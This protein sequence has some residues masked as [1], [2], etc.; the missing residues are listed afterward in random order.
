MK[1]WLII[2]IL[3]VATRSFSETSEQLAGQLAEMTLTSN[4]WAQLI[5]VWN[6]HAAASN[7]EE[8]TPE[9][10]SAMQEIMVPKVKA[11]YIT[12]CTN[13]YTKSELQTL[14]TVEKAYG[15][16]KAS[17]LSKAMRI[18]LEINKTIKQATSEMFSSDNSLLA[19]D[20]A[21]IEYIKYSFYWLRLSQ[22][23]KRRYL[24]AAGDAILCSLETLKAFDAEKTDLARDVLWED[25]LLYRE[26]KYEVILAMDNLY[27]EEANEDKDFDEILFLAKEQVQSEQSD[28]TDEEFS[29]E[30]AE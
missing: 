7:K 19:E 29:D 17:L 11:R 20:D 5:E 10:F 15:S 13:I 3:F 25:V 6:E 8:I 1:S 28:E 16:A 14:L 22:K 12:L 9:F 24:M 4:T 27:S 23:E 21:P 30:T 26:H 2:F 18:Q